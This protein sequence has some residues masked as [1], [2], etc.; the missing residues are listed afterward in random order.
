VFL[1]GEAADA[2]Q[3]QVLLGR[4]RSADLDAV[5]A[6]AHWDQVLGTVQEDSDRL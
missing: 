3:A 2:T 1:L 5:F 4:Y 6:L